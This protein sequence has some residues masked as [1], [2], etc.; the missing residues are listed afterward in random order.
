MQP[1]SRT[2]LLRTLIFVGLGGL[3]VLSWTQRGRFTP[4]DVGSAAPAYAAATINGE[5]FS[6]AAARGK[7]VVL[8]VWAT[9]CPPCRVE[10]PA[11]ERLH[12]LL[13]ARGVEVVAVSTDA[14]QGALGP[15]GQPGG[16]VRAYVKEMGLTFRVVHDPDRT[17]EHA[18]LVQGLP[19]TFVIDKHGRIAQK[20]IGARAWDDAG[21]V[22]FLE[23]LL[24]EE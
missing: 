11:L 9:W 22:A 14:R 1:R 2:R 24:K 15:L 20:V 23:K 7:V 10:M 17:I 13:G 19:T 4:V 18:Y 8:N 6:I 21:N 5:P 3:L 12:E 16:D